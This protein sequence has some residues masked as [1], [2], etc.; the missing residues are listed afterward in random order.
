MID[1][2]YFDGGVITFTSGANNGFAMEVKSYVPGQI[3]LHLPM[4]YP[5]AAGD[6]YSMVGGCDKSLRTCIDRYNNVVNF[7]GEP[8]LPGLDKVLQTGR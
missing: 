8:Y 7:R 2:G 4:P 6:T 1:S 3:S 5:V